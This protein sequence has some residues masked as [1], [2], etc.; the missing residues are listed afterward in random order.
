MECAF[1]ERSQ[2]TER[3]TDGT[4]HIRNV[5]WGPDSDPVDLDR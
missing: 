2:E 4:R 3:V 5:V 1:H